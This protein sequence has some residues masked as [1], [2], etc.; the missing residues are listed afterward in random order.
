M[1]NSLSDRSITLPPPSLEKV[2]ALPADLSKPDFGLSSSQL[3]DLR[4]KLSLV[5][6]SAWAVNFNL[7][8]QAFEDQHIAAVHSFLS[9][10]Q[11]TT[12]GSPARFYFCSSVSSVGGTPRPGTVPETHVRDIGHV[13]GTGYA[14]SK[15][16]AEQ[17]VYNAAKDSGAE[18]R[19]LRIG[20][21]SG[22][23][24]A[25]EWNVTEGVPMLIQTA[26]TLGCL[27]SLDEEMSWLPV[28]TAASIILDLALPHTSTSPA[29]NPELVYHVLNPHR[30]NWTRDMLP[31][32]SASGI[33]FDTVPTEE[34][35]EKLRSSD[36]DPSRNP[37]I[38]LL[39]WF[40][41]KYGEKARGKPKGVLDFET[42]ETE[43]GSEM[44]G[45]V[46]DVTEKEYVAK[47]V[48][49]LGQRWGSV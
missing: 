7:P 24:L 41:S 47:V 5:I 21:L 43:R 15:Y 1:L 36:P 29:Q 20:Q 45:R 6:H 25:G 19:V 2:F 11:S 22:D 14:R 18:A 3:D 30:F 37:P 26:I 9:L 38:K 13:Q 46:P 32:L 39:G 4:S 12:H 28:D 42:G 48:E 33:K 16:V 27:P 10:C 35:M 23:T 31:A 40:E 17:I 49:R 34:W 8:V 44:M